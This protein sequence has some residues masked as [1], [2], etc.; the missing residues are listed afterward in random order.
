MNIFTYIFIV[1]DQQIATF[2]ADLR[3]LE[4]NGKKFQ[5]FEPGFWLDWWSENTDFLEANHQ[6]DFAFLSEDTVRDMQ[7]PEHWQSIKKSTWQLESI[8]QLLK[9]EFSNK[10]CNVFEN[11]K[12]IFPPI[13]KKLHPLVFHLQRRGFDATPSIEHPA[14]GC[15]KLYRDMR[16]DPIPEEVIK[17]ISKPY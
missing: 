1:K 6:I 13:D 14:E 7:V 15:S 2:R 12:S 11:G 4:A 17:R 10:H 8:Q 5:P 9:V 16:D 3:C